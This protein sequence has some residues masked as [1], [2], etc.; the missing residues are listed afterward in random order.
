MGIGTGTNTVSAR[1]HAIK[2][3][4]Q[5]R[6]GY[7]TSNYLSA[8]VGSTGVVTFDAVG[9]G[10]AFSFS[11]DVTVVGSGTTC[12]I[13]TGTGAT[14][15]TSDARLKQ[16]VQDLGSVLDKV[17]ALRPVTFR[18]NEIS[19]HDQSKV[20]VG[21][22]AQEVQTLFPDSVNTV[23]GDYLGIDYA[24]LTVPVV[25]AIKEMNMKVDTLASLDTTLEGSLAQKILAFLANAVVSIKDAT[26]GTLRVNTEVCADD[27][28]VT[29]DEFKQ[30]LL[31]AKNGAGTTSIPIPIGGGAGSGDTGTPTDPGTSGADSTPT[32]TGT[33]GGDA[34]TT[35]TPPPADTPA[36]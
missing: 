8:T 9:S 35:D 33:S 28:C 25:E 26:I 2:T 21:F 10:H 6:L 15:C 30:L 18:W 7:D 23:Y 36:P 20:H 5:L 22:I 11:D 13:G 12:V 14:N 3:T 4:E 17:V 1:I 32:D 27:V 16:D 29:K 31:Q 19:G 24:S 34:G